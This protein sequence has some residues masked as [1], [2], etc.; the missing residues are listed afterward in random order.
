MKIL[1]IFNPMSGFRK[2]GDPKTIIQKTLK[3]RGYSYEWFETIKAKRQPL[4]QFKNKKYDKIIVSGGDGTVAEVASFLIEHKIKTP[5]IIIPQGSGNILAVS[6]RLP[7]TVGRALNKGLNNKGKE[8]DAIRVNNRYYSLIATGCGYD[9]IVMSKTPRSL[10]RK[11]GVL[12]YA[13]TILKTIFYYRSKPYRLSIDGRRHILMAKS[14]MCFN[15]LP[16]ANL[17]ITEPFIGHRILPDDGLIN[18]YAL[19][20]R[21]IRD[22]LKFRKAIKI[23]T[24]K[25]ISIKS[26]RNKKYQIDGN[27]FKGRTVN[28]E[29]MHNAI[30]IVY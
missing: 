2:W 15:I 3:K 30:R 23:F 26:K 22:F 29:V 17:K 9:T 1:I 6:L 4:D 7:L 5:L 20:P 16:L 11:V 8:L 27:V 25:K 18:I 28:L 12:A 10:K 14:I 19:N 13:W 21:P 24:G